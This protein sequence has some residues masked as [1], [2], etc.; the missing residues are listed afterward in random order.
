MSSG[1]RG[2]VKRIFR[3]TLALGIGLFLGGLTPG[4]RAQQQEPEVAPCRVQ[5]G[6]RQVHEDSSIAA[7]STTI[8]A[9]ARA[10]RAGSGTG[11]WGPYEI[12]VNAAGWLHINGEEIGVLHQSIGD[13]PTYGGDPGRV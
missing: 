10:I 7:G 3:N 12:E 9:C 5:R 8:G 13:D 4:T 11:T 1:K 6:D 2:T